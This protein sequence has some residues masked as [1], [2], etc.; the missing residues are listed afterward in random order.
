M[1]RGFTVIELIVTLGI[2][3]VLL[4]LASVNLLS[5]Q[6]RTSVNTALDILHSD[7]HN[8]QMDAIAKGG[9]ARGIYFSADAYTLF[10]GSGYIPGD[11]ANFT[12][13]LSPGQ[14]F[15]S[16]T[17]PSSAIVFLPKSG[18]ISGF[19]PGSNSVTLTDSQVNQS[20]T[21]TLNAYGVVTAVY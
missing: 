1:R 9:V 19:N 12:V 16:V 15:S 14:Q 17:F 10:T 18:Q 2:I 5:S 8:Q 11:P 13:S 4:T 6:R 3:T 7:L 20:Y 21:L